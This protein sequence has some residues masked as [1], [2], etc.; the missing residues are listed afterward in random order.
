MCRIRGEEI[1]YRNRL[2]YATESQGELS[3]AAVLTGSRVRPTTCG[4]GG[5]VNCR[6]A[7]DD[8]GPARRCVVP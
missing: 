7:A 6:T 1:G 3:C 4:G 5:R 2:G 8:P